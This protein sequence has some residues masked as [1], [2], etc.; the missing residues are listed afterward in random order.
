MS[1]GG[2][3]QPRGKAKAK[4]VAKGKRGLVTKK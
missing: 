2:L 3:V 4:P 1:K